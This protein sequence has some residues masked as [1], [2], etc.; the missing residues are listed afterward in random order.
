MKDEDLKTFKEV[1]ANPEQYLGIVVH[2][3]NELIDDY[4]TIKQHVECMKDQVRYLENRVEVLERRIKDAEPTLKLLED[5]S[6][7][8]RVWKYLGYLITWL[9]GVVLTIVGLDFF[10]GDE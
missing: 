2:R 4:E 7:L 10:K 6:S 8:S 3:Q 1:T 9:L 5:L